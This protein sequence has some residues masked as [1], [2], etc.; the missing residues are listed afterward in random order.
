MGNARAR[1][2]DTAICWKLDKFGRS[3]LDFLTNLRDLDSHGV[4]F[5]ATTQ[6]LDTDNRNPASKFLL[7]VLGA[8]A[9][10]ERD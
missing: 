2:V 7:H 4:R 1:K 9:E 5:V 6:A 10:F 3:L 8:I